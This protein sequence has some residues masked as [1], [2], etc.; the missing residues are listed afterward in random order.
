MKAKLITYILGFIIVIQLGILFTIYIP[1]YFNK[2]KQY[3]SLSFY[4]YDYDY[5]TENRKKQIEKIIKNG[6]ILKDVITDSC[7]Y[8]FLR[9]EK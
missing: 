3:R 4:I 2:E 1:K 9:F 6:F 8:V 5:S 7:G